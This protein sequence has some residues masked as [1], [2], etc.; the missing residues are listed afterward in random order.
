M[1]HD[2]PIRQGLRRSSDV[3]VAAWVK[4]GVGR[5]GSGV[6]SLVPEGF[7]CHARILHPAHGPD[8]DEATVPWTVVAAWAGRSMHRLVQFEAIATPQAGA[9][10]GRRPWSSPPMEGAPPPGVLHALR[11]SLSAHTSA[12]GNCWFCLWEG[13]GWIEGG[14]GLGYG[15]DAEASTE[16]PPV[17]PPEGVEVP[18]V[19]LPQPTTCSSRIRSRQ[20]RRSAGDSAINVSMSCPTASWGRPASYPSR[21]TSSGPTTAPGSWHPRSTSTRPTW[22]AQPSS[23]P[24]CSPTRG[25]KSGRRVGGTASISGPI[26]S[27]SR[28]RRSAA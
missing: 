16:L 6:G 20:Q 3:S 21:R 17:F 25:W 13:W 7:E 8:D 23:S 26:R 5:F 15:E 12:P 18:R 22:A 27:T 10:G 11:D 4:A 9:G 14:R 1:S 24:I 28:A 2:E 19:H